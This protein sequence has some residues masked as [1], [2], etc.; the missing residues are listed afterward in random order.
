[1]RVVLDTNVLVSAVLG[2]VLAK[3]LDAW[4]AGRF[5]LL[6][7]DEVLYEYRDVLSRPKFELT[8]DE[9]DGIVGYV[10]HH[11]EFVTVT[12]SLRVVESDPDDD[13]F[14]EVALAGRANLIVS[15]DRHLLALESYEHIPVI[16]GRAFL[17]GLDVGRFQEP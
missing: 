6:V 4:Y 7:N 9:V 3:I 10:F 16:A 14:L 5:T 12:R 13:K 11:A 15:G 1:M 17:D 2:G 8:L